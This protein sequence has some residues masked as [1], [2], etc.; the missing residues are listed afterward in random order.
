VPIDVFVAGSIQQI[1]IDQK[2]QHVEYLAVVNK[3]DSAISVVRLYT[4][5]VPSNTR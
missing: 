1:R 4:W 2:A 5:S 3:A